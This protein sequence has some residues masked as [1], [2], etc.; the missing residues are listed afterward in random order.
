MATPSFSAEI[1]LYRTPHYY[2]S[3]SGL[4]RGDTIARDRNT[5]TPASASVCSCPCC[6]EHHCGFLGLSHCLTCCDEHGTLM[7]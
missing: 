4:D 7:R 1:A 5:L 6:M 2:S 3:P